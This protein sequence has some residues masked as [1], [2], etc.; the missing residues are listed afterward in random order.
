MAVPRAQLSAVARVGAI[1]RR[2]GRAAGGGTGTRPGRGR[3]SPTLP[4]AHGRARATSWIGGV[5]GLARVGAQHGVQ[6]PLPALLLP[7]TPRAHPPGRPRGCSWCARAG[8]CSSRSPGRRPRIGAWRGSRRARR[9][10]PAAARA[11]TSPAS[12]GSRA[13][14]SAAGVRP[15]AARRFPPGLASP[16]CAPGWTR[17]AWGGTATSRTATCPACANGWRSADSP[18]SRCLCWRTSAGRRARPG[19]GCGR[20]LRRSSPPIASTARRT[21]CGPHAPPPGRGG[22]RASR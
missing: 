2:R 19:A 10:A 4:G 6:P 9:P 22:C 5:V 13:A 1:A 20:G 7:S 11:A 15:G 18:S 8:R 12:R 17:G 14:R 16:S 3:A 21:T